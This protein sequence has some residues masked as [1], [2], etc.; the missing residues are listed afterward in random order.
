MQEALIVIIAITDLAA[1][2]GTVWL[3]WGAPWPL[4]ILLY[5]IPAILTWV[6]GRTIEFFVGAPWTQERR[7]QLRVLS[8]AWPAILA[9]ALVILLN[10]RNSGKP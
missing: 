9:Y 1:I 5:V 8:L 2:I 4:W 3:L 6:L 10:W 7:K